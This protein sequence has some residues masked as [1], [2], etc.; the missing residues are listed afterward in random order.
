MEIGRVSVGA[1]FYLKSGK[2]RERREYIVVASY[3]PEDN[4][5]YRD[6]V[7]NTI[8]D[9]ANSEDDKISIPCDRFVAHILTGE[10]YYTCLTPTSVN[11]DFNPQEFLEKVRSVYRELSILADFSQ[12]F[13][14][15]KAKFSE[16]LKEIIETKNCQNLT[17]LPVV[18]DEL[19]QVRKVLIESVQKLIDR[20][21][22]L[23]ELVKKTQILEITMRKDF[24]LTQRSTKKKHS[25][26]FAALLS[27][28]MLLT[29]LAFGIFVYVQFM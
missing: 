20:G 9:S 28:V 10:L 8:R 25:V 14:K 15:S 3:P 2:L 6:I 27:I 29:C 21:Q 18:K 12:E 24:Q 26:C 7:L 11:I 13:Q 4:P 22:R 1:L 17:S 16:P 5:Y 19:A 23:E